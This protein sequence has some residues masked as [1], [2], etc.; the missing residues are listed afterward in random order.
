MLWKARAQLE[1]FQMLFSSCLHCVL[2]HLLLDFAFCPKHGSGVLSPRTYSCLYGDVASGMQW[3]WVRC[4]VGMG[5]VYSGGGVVYS[6][7]GH[8]AQWGWGGAQWG[9]GCVQ[10][11]WLWFTVE[12]GGAILPFIVFSV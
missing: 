3:G 1:V 7:D 4:T 6:V 8:G 9:W 10:W 12:L 5:V 11:G 2:F